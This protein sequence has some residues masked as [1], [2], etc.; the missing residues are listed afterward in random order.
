MKRKELEQIIKSGGTPIVFKTFDINYDRT[1]KR[2]IASK[3]VEDSDGEIVDLSG[4]DFTRFM[5]NPVWL[6]GH[7]SYGEIEDVIG[8]VEDIKIEYDQDGKKMMTYTGVYAPHEKAQILKA[9][10]EMDMLLATSIGFRVMEYDFDNATITKWELYEIS[11]VIL[12]ANSEA[13]AMASE[14][15]LIS[16][17]VQDNLL[18]EKMHPVYKKKLKEYRK[19]F[20]SDELFSLLNLEKSGKE[21]ADLRNLHDNILDILKSFKE[22]PKEESI[23]TENQLKEIQPKTLSQDELNNLV[24]K[25]FQ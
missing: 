4:G 24:N 10:H 20:M 2:F 19:L 7:R 8:K 25:Y 1:N 5:K 18:K 9:M 6:F 12:P 22:N 11:N 15:G 16:K 3:E 23:I 13:I 21:L 17:D 14:K